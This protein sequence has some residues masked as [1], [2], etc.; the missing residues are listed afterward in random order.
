[1]KRTSVLSATLAVLALVVTACG[2]GEDAGGIPEDAFPIVANADLAV[3]PQRLLVGLFNQEAQSHTSPELGVEVD[4]Y[5]P[6]A[7]EPTITTPGTFMWTVPE[8]R[9]LYRAQVTFDQPGMWQISLRAG[10]GDTT[11]RIPF[12]V[13]EHGITPAVGE[14]APPAATPTE[15]D[16]VD[17][18]EISTDPDPDPRF[19]QLSLDEALASGVPTVVVFA[20]PGFCESATCGPML[21]TVNR[22]ASI[23]RT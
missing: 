13:A 9:G 4:L 5:P 16:V 19:Y 3:G 18:S 12:D 15:V 14:S 22:S 17:L 6:N 23:T 2:R 21:E 20:T 11:Q 7:E 10:D 1:M 8:V